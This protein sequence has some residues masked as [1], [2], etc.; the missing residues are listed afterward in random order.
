MGRKK[1]DPRYNV[2][3]VRLTDEE[4]A[5]IDRIAKRDNAGN[6]S[7]LLHSVLSGWLQVAS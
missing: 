5:A 7:E 2:V 6:L 1:Q 4:R 3:S